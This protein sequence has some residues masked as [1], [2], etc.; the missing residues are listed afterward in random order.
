[1]LDDTLAKGLISS[2]D[3]AFGPVLQ[4]A[5][6]G[7][8]PG[9]FI[10]VVKISA[11][12]TA[13]PLFNTFVGSR[14]LKVASRHTI[15]LYSSHKQATS[16]RMTCQVDQQVLRQHLDITTGLHNAAEKAERSACVAML[17]ANNLV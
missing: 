4:H 15:L 1:M 13:M 11:I 16:L 3:Q 10:A 6:C 8:V 14:S 5:S 9:H 2:L 12:W 7:W 17:A